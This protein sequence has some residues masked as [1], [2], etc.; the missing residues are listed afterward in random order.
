MSIDGQKSAGPSK[1]AMA[2]Q[3]AAPADEYR[4]AD[5]AP[6]GDLPCAISSGAHS[7]NRT[8][9]EHSLMGRRSRSLRSGG[10][11]H[12]LRKR[13]E[14]AFAAGLTLKKGTVAD[15]NKP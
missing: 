8:L 14:L 4:R 7:H 6:D 9:P 11:Q 1:L 10:M 12:D 3:I 5:I 13:S 15:R 2:H